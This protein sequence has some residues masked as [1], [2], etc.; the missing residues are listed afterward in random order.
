MTPLFDSVQLSSSLRV[1]SQVF[2]VLKFVSLAI[3]LWMMSEPESLSFRSYPILCLTSWSVHHQWLSLFTTAATVASCRNK[4]QGPTSEAHV[5]LR[6]IVCK[7]LAGSNTSSDKRRKTK[8]SQFQVSTVASAKAITHAARRLNVIN[9]NLIDTW[10]VALD[11]W[12]SHHCEYD[13]MTL[14]RVQM[15][16]WCW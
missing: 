3:F 16:C 1:A 2:G 12:Q 13:R 8:V 5:L 10:S 7:R 6:A 11:T 15:D 4:L 14:N 9:S